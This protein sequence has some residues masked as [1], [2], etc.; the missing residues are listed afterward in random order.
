MRTLAS[1]L[2]AVLLTACGSSD[3]GITSGPSSC[4]N[5]DQKQ[6]VFEVMSDWYLWNDLLPSQ[7]SLN[8]YS[9]PEALLAY[10]TSFQP[11]DNFSFII[12]AEADALFLAAGQFEGFGFNSRFLSVDDWRFTRVFSASPAG[13]AGFARGQRIIELNGRTIAEIQAAEGVA[14][15]LDTAPVLFTIRELDDTEFTVSV[16]PDV[17]TIAPVP[18]WRI[19]DAGAGRS[20]GYMELAQFISTADPVFETVFAEFRSAGVND[21]IIDVRYNGGGLVS[22]ANLLGDYLGGDVAENLVFSMTRFNA[23]RAA[24]N[25]STEFFDRLGSS[26]SLSRLVIIATSG[27]ASASELVTNSLEPH[28]D[29]T[30]VGSTTFG[31]PVGQAGFEFCDK[32][33]RPTTFQTVNADDFGDYFG[34]LPVDCPA[35]DDLD[36]AIGADADPNLVAALSYLDTG[37]CPLILLPGGL[38]KP[39]LRAELMQLER[40]GSPA[41]VYA[42]AF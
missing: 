37:S 5:G 16:S 29:V 26:L 21:L 35:A 36:F 24:E 15:V 3:G 12:S 4:S 17:V 13:V 28:V 14:A 22:T 32:I 20:V 27:T 1:L 31:K 8:A 33:L 42:D 39:G 18:Q 19:I 2:T 11:L 30:I 40:R 10:L 7:V 6:F 41:R 9:S 25:D 38:S 23:D 34:G